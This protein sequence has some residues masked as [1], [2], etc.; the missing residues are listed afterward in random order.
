MLRRGLLLFFR[1]ASG[2]ALAFGYLAAGSW[3]GAVIALL[4][5]LILA[6]HRRVHSSWLPTAYLGSMVCLAGVDVLMGAPA[7]PMVLSC[8]F[9]LGAWDL[10][11]LERSIRGSEST[12]AAGR[13]EKKHLGALALALG[14]GLALAAAGLALSLRLPFIVMLFLVILDLFC[15]ERAARFLTKE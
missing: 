2:A 5:G 12:E 3:P 4:P 8:A 14:L 10:A 6:F 7:V 1:G 11:N 13:L 15:L 9:A